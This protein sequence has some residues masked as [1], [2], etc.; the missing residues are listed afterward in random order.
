MKPFIFQTCLGLGFLTAIA[1][2]ICF[3]LGI[4]GT[5]LALMLSFICLA[6]GF[7]GFP[8]LKGFSYTLFIFAASTYALNYP[9]NLVSFQGYLL[10][11]L[12][13]PLLVITMFGMGIHM[14]LTRFVEIVKAPKPIL[15]GIFCHYLIMP[16][17]GFGLAM[18]TDLPPE[19][20]AGII[21]V[22]CSPSGVASNVMAYISGGN[23]ALSVTVTAISTLLAP[24]VTP[25]LMKLLANQLVPINFWD[26]FWHILE[27]VIFPVLA[28]LVYNKYAY[29]KQK[30]LDDLLPIL[31]M[32]SIIFIV[33]LTVSA[34]HDTLLSIGWLLIL[35]VIVH[36]LS[37]YFFGYKISKWMGINE[38]DSRTIAFEV[39]LQNAG[40]ATGI[41]AKMGF[42][43]TMG[44]VPGIFGSMQNITAS[45]LA[46]WWGRKK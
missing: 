3:F 35:I 11:K 38:Q 4:P 9:E 31:S 18:T 2:S 6:L 15:A 5:A 13:T 12:V 37:G 26:M 19:I 41:A 22:G 28:G 42:M 16:G 36:N 21:L 23:L 27:I 8:I 24:L 29:G 1:S 39:G 33:A 43:A 34:G 30:W 20:A 7:Q 17:I 10:K 46:N 14:N 44:L 45:V 25:L 40:L 32:A